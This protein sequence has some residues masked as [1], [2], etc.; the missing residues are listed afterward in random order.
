MSYNKTV[1]DFK[2]DLQRD[3]STLKSDTHLGH[4]ASMN[5]TFSGR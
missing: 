4:A 5:I 3:L 1:I 2:F